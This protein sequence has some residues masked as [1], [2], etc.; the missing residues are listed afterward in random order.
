MDG[1]FRFVIY[2]ASRRCYSI[3]RYD[4]CHGVIDCISLSSGW[5]VLVSVPYLALV[6]CRL[7]VSDIADVEFEEDSDGFLEA[8]DLDLD[9]DFEAELG[10]AAAVRTSIIL[11]FLTGE[12]Y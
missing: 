10:S 2:S 1:F 12:L 11:C 6:P 8:G 9:D 7:Y 3:S 5:E 4:C